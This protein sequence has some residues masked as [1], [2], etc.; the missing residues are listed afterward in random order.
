MTMPAVSGVASGFGVS[1]S[2][3][4]V[5]VGVGGARVAVAVAVGGT[6]VDVGGTGVG[7]IHSNGMTG[8]L[9]ASIANRRMPMAKVP[10]VRTLVRLSS[11]AKAC[12]PNLGWFLK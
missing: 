1:A 8:E 5:T 9:Q 2:G 3:M 10:G 12:T 11:Q 4:S 7:V 6:G